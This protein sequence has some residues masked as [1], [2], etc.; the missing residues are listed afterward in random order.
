MDVFEAIRKRRSVRSY[1]LRDVEEKDL[2]RVLEAGRLA[3]SATNRQDWRFVVV[4][5][6]S[7]REKLAVAAQ[8]QRFVAE[9]PV[10]IVACAPK[11]DYIMPCGHP[12]YLIDVAIAV[13]H[14]TLAARELEL[15]TCWVG[16]FNQQRV[17]EIL[18]IPGLA[19]VVALLLLGHPKAWPN[20]KP[21]KSLLQVVSYDGW[22]E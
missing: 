20:P 16:A 21:R 17:R 2:R 5:D 6:R 19:K 13:D 12:S 14:M 22:E 10:V 9:A 7:L 8:N 18:A 15:G 3:P 4:R 1:K 11:A